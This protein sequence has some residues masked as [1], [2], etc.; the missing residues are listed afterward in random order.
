[1]TVTPYTNPQRDPILEA[2]LQSHK[3][4]IEWLI[5]RIT[6]LEAQ[7]Y[8]MNCATESED[9]EPI[10]LAEIIRYAADMKRFMGTH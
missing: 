6:H 5:A 4:A 3:Q 1:M 7:L 2:E 8:E 10:P 9:N